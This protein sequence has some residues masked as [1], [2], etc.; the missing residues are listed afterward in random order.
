MKKNIF[1]LLIKQGLKGVFRYKTQFILIVILGFFASLIL[2]VTN[3]INDRIKFE[4]ERTMH[5]VEPFDFYSEDSLETIGSINSKNMVPI[6]DFISDEYLKDNDGNP[7]AYNVNIANVNGTKETFITE[8]LKNDK[9]KTAFNSLINNK[10]YYNPWFNYKFTDGDEKPYFNAYG[11]NS[12]NSNIYQTNYW[13][14][15]LKIINAEDVNYSPVEVYTNE[16]NYYIAKQMKNFTNTTISLLK[17]ELNNEIVNPNSNFRSQ[18]STFA[19]LV[20]KGILKS[21]DI[22]SDLADYN[23]SELSNFQREINTYIDF[24]FVSIVYQLNKMIHDY[25]QYWMDK[26]IEE[27][28]ENPSTELVLNEFKKSSKLNNEN[29][30]GNGDI[31]YNWLF[32]DDFNSENS[33]GNIYEVGA[34]G[35]LIHADQKGNVDDKGDALKLISNGKYLENILKGKNDFIKKDDYKYENANVASSYYVRQ[36]LIAQASELD[37]NSRMEIVYSDNSSEKHFRFILM[38]QWVEENVTVYQ[39][40]KPRTK[41]EVLVNPQYAKA[42]KINLGSNIKVGQA[43]LIVS[44]FAADPYTN[45]PVAEM[46]VPFPNNKKGAIIY[47]N[48]NI[49]NEVIARNEAKVATTNLYRFITSKNKDNLD[50]NISIFKSLNYNYLQNLKEDNEN[51]EGKSNIVYPYSL[52]GF[53]SSVFSINW[54]LMPLVLKTFSTISYIVC[55]IILAI[56]IVTMLIAIKK[57]IQFNSGE[58]GILKA[59]GTKTSQIAISYISYGLVLLLFVVPITWFIGG[60]VQELFSILFISYTGGAYNQARFSPEALAI[61]MLLFGLGTILVSY[62]TAYILIKKPVLE[63]LNKKEVVKRI[64]WLDNLKLRLTKRTKFTTKFSIELAISGI[65]PTLVS[66]F[67]VLIATLLVTTSMSIPGMVNTAVTSYYKNVKYSNQIENLEPIGNSPLSKTSLSP[68][69]GVD[70]YEQYLNNVKG[71]YGTVD[72]LSD[73]ITNVTGPTDYSIL[74]KFLFRKD[75]TNGNQ[76]TPNWTYD[77]L[78]KNGEL[79][80]MIGYLFGSGLPQ[81]IGRGINIADIQRIIEWLAHTH[82]EENLFNST[83]DRIKRIDE[84]T[85]LLSEGLPPILK[86]IFP[87]E[88]DDENASNWKDYIM[89]A[90][91]SETPSY[92]KSYLSKSENRYNQ[93]SF[94]WTFTNYI[95]GEDDFYTS[96]K[97]ITNQNKQMSLVGVQSNQKAYNLKEDSNKMYLDSESLNNLEKVLKGDS[98]EDITTKNGFKLYSNGNLYIPVTLN[99]QA[100]FKMNNSKDSI[101]G[102]KKFIAKRFVMSQDGVNIP[103]SAWVYDDE[104]WIEVSRSSNSRDRYLDPATLDTSKFTFASSYEYTSNDFSFNRAKNAKNIKDYAKGFANFYTENEILKTEVRPY[105]NYDNLF[106]IIPDKYED[107]LTALSKGDKKNNWYGPLTKKEVP[108]STKKQWEKVLDGEEP[109][110]YIWIRP[111]SMTYDSN[112]QEQE[113]GGEIVNLLAYK[114]SFMRQNLLESNPGIIDKD[115]QMDWNLKSINLVPV[116]TVDVYGKNVI[117]ADQGLANLVH[118]YSNSQYIPYNYVFEKDQKESYKL[119]DGQS[120]KTYTWN[121]AE[122]LKKRNIEDQIWGNN[123]QKA[124]SPS[125]WFTG[126]MSQSKEPYFLTSQASFSKNIKT[127]E[128]TLGGESKYNDTVEMESVEFLTEQK[129]LINQIANLILTIAISFIVVI[130]I[131]A[132]LSMIIITDLYVNQYR[133]FMIVM[134]SLGYS[135]WKVIKYS[136]GTVTLLALIALLLGIAGSIVMVT[137][138]GNYVKHNV[139]SIPLGLSWWALLISTLLL[140]AS[141]IGS[142]LITTY[143]IRKESPVSLMK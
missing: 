27:N 131:T 14:Q 86:S 57:T 51:N 76:A 126:I 134:K 54:I 93:Y 104:D 25:V 35:Q 71:N 29:G 36:N 110:K 50:K 102:I 70:Y 44:G 34:K 84:L 127:G 129:A 85:S 74:P 123:E 63:I 128:F 106:L 41:N 15:T 122:D 82:E 137:M 2:S 75:S 73:S 105:Y 136:F 109:E 103:N 43:N 130:I 18:N 113:I 119:A 48:K 116:S 90:I 118:G 7:L 46:T 79:I 52:K 120:I 92:V 24:A 112:Y 37:L 42:N 1:F 22:V 8:A 142:I 89:A 64:Q 39:G 81:T 31:L 95:P 124:Y 19:I 47:L 9:F 117:L 11:I 125:N 80:K 69:N 135:N 139:G 6:M 21:E 114:N 56:C 12:T 78:S 5:K 138:T 32:S 143:K 45:F 77:T 100:R 68:W 91:L 20:N 4:Y 62:I 61:L 67:T 10:E 38:D 17:E 55:S 66:T 108:E 58:I 115:V 26:A 121:T 96:T 98:T 60:Y 140:V 87:G 33:T 107:S 133:K 72:Y 59:L 94:G 97:F 13:Y 3:S 49:V 30:N 16:D 99:D 101:F 111:Y 65:K 23:Y 40:N 88:V 83:Q 141:F 53:K 28:S 132:T